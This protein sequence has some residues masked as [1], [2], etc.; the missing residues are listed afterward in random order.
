MVLK[1]RKKGLDPNPDLPGLFPTHD[2]SYGIN[3]LINIDTEPKKGQRPNAGIAQEQS[4]DKKWVKSMKG[5]VA[6][7]YGMNSNL[8][9]AIDESQK[10]VEKEQHQGQ[11]P[12]QTASHLP[13]RVPPSSSSSSSSAS[14]YRP[15]G[16]S[17]PSGSTSTSISSD[18]MSGPKPPGGGPGGPSK[19]PDDS[20]IITQLTPHIPNYNP[21]KL[22][23]Q[24]EFD[25][26]SRPPYKQAD[27]PSANQHAHIDVYQNI[28]PP[29]DDIPFYGMPQ[30]AGSN[31]PISP[32]RPDSS[33]SF[34]YESGLFAN[35]TLQTPSQ[36][37]GR[38][39]APQPTSQRLGPTAQTQTAAQFGAT[40]IYGA[41]AQPPGQSSSSRQ[42][43]LQE[44]A[45]PSIQQSTSGGPATS[46]PRPSQQRQ[47]TPTWQ[48]IP[49]GQTTSNPIH[50]SQ[51]G[52]PT[53]GQ[54]T[55]DWRPVSG[56]QP[57]PGMPLG[58]QE[59]PISGV[60]AM[61][62]APPDSNQSSL[63]HEV[64]EVSPV[65]RNPR[66]EM[67]DQ[68]PVKQA[69]QSKKITSQPGGGNA[70]QRGSAQNGRRQDRRPIWVWPSSDL[71]AR[72]I[73]LF[74]VLALS[75]WFILSAIPTGMDGSNLDPGLPRANLNLP[76]FSFGAMWKKLSDLLPEIPDLQNLS[77]DDSPNPI[78]S[79]GSSDSNDINS[80]EFLTEVKKLMPEAIWVQ[81]NKSGKLRIPEDFWHALR[82]LIEKDK[83]ILS[84]KNSNISE[85]HWRAIESR[86]Q[87]SGI[88]KTGAS[89]EDVEV[90][91]ERTI[92]Q[93][94]DSWLK[95]NDKAT[96][97]AATGV[98][99][100]RDDFMKLFQ[101]EIA[102]YRHEIRQELKELQNR[103]RDITQ[104][105]SKLRKD[106]I[107]SGQLSK[108]EM[109]K[110]INSIV[111]KA[112]NSVKLDAVAQGLIK[113]HANDVLANQVNFFA[114]G[115]GAMIDTTFNSRAW[116]GPK[117][118][119]KSKGWLE[120][121]YRAQPPLAALSPWS[122]E[123][124]CFCAGL[125]QKGYGEGTNNIS[126]ITSRNIIPQ[127]LV[128]EHI[129][130]GA[131]L[132]P[133]AIPKEIEVWVYIEEVTLRSEVR[134]FS[135]TNFPNTPKEEVLNDGFVKIG[136]FIYE[137]KNSGDG[138]QVFKI[139]DEMA[140]MNA[141]THRVVIRAINNYGADH[142][143]FYRIRLYGE[144]VE[145]PDDLP[146]VNGRKP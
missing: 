27:L 57:V 36:P 44:Q 75:L 35:A 72:S 13:G 105:M 76:N 114:F 99:L 144:I 80:K 28:S 113:G 38:F 136:H 67:E 110:L 137:N 60:Q 146:Y 10:Q 84:L 32:T 58:L 134:T 69:Q 54:S 7:K 56:Q 92:S 11:N 139:S 42:P 12:P 140:R 63:S 119:F 30:G 68:G 131:T 41:G 4:D 135:E 8:K 100:T 109:T 26:Q 141:F 45:G 49:G 115:A 6:K 55:S 31:E 9:K 37:I 83:S 70:T 120:K 53:P 90:L 33:R 124:E 122:Q 129:L 133:G 46:G 106:I 102:S 22:P 39:G 15:S 66:L 87:T 95:Q 130:P 14:S 5:K 138:V 40:G 121:N 97:K 142:T 61:L 94:W 107:P 85:D 65:G 73:M 103:I 91:V 86:I 64:P 1:T 52:Q 101:Q 123:G 62:H 117:N 71:V 98:A 112:I 18:H 16:S 74:L 48:P 43:N 78:N 29:S 24:E 127:H 2:G 20:G 128:V 23:F 126:V 77:H 96:K 116:S 143:C 132:D 17:G 104:R 59:Q 89:T 125:D 145:R 3:T 19:P 51:Q 118:P 111:S 25:D 88:C 34:N 108:D 79:P 50:P 93:S 82:Q 21:N 47:P 81:E